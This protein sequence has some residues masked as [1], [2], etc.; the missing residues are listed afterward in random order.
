VAVDDLDSEVVERTAVG[1]ADDEVLDRRLPLL[2]EGPGDEEKAPAKA[3]VDRM[4]ELHR[5]GLRS[6]KRRRSS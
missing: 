4:K 3:D 6:R 2:F 5:N 1:A